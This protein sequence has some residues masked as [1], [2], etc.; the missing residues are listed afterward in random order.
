MANA[1][2]LLRRALPLSLVALVLT[3]AC[4]ARGQTPEDGVMLK[5]GLLCTGVLYSHDDWSKYWEGSIKRDNGNIGTVTTQTVNNSSNYAVLNRLNVFATTPY[6]W[7]NVSQGVLH[8][9]Q[10][11]QDI[12]LAVKYQAFHFPVRDFADFRAFA[13][14]SGSLPLTHYEPDLLPL[15][16]GTHTRTIAPRA[17]LNFQ[18]NDGAFANF[19]AAYVF[20]GIVTLDRPYYYTNG[21]LYF[22]NQVAMPNQFQYT[23]SLGY[24]KHDLMLSGEFI[25]QQTRG[26]GD[27]R[28]QDMPFISNR[29]NESRAGIRTQIP[30]PKIRNLQAWFA[31][32]YTWQGRNVGQSNTITTGFMYTLHFRRNATL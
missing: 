7:T 22:S 29:M 8:S 17:T 20:R 10:G 2:A 32:D 13:V 26:G 15:S 3:L 25:E 28:R 27:I 16:I 9:Q 12:S 21:Q 14:V 30:I 11:F 1:H 6:V 23:V 19:T 18:V 4:P 5:R 24:L 31:D